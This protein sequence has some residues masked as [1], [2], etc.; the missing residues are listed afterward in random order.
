MKLRNTPVI[1][2]AGLVEMQGLVSIGQGSSDQ[3]YPSIAIGSKTCLSHFL[4]LSRAP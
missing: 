2:Q 1:G 4:L 3:D